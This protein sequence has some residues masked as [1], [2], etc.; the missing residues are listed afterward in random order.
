MRHTVIAAAMLCL[1]CPGGNGSH[2]R[3]SR[4]A[5][6]PPCDPA[7]VV[8]KVSRLYDRAGVTNHGRAA[9]LAEL[10]SACRARRLSD[11]QLECI[12]ASESFEALS[13]C[14]GFRIDDQPTRRD[15]AGGDLPAQHDRRAE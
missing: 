15:H 9:T 6:H 2:D 10:D 12:A 3:G 14:D 8:G 7:A 11:R 1:A 5:T 4:T 13:L